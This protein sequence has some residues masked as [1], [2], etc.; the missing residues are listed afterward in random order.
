MQNSGFED[1]ELLSRSNGV[2]SLIPLH[3]CGNS[4]RNCFK[5][6]MFGKWIF[7]KAL[8]PVLESDSRYIEAFRKEQEIGLQL[9]HPN[10]PKYV[11]TPDLLPG[12]AFVA[13]EY[14]DGITLEKFLEANKNYFSLASH[15]EKFIRE[16]SSA[17]DYL[18]SHQILHLDLKPDNILI[19]RVGHN[20][21]II[22]FGFSKTDS[23]TGSE[24]FTSGFISPERVLSKDRTESADYYGLGKLLEYIR[25]HTPDYPVKKF[26]KLE[27]GLLASEPLRRIHTEREI[28]RML[29][30]KSRVPFLPFGI[31]L[32][33]V[34]GVAAAFIFMRQEKVPPV[35]EH[36]KTEAIREERFSIEDA[37]D[38]PAGAG[39]ATP[40]SVEQ[41]LTPLTRIPPAPE[42]TLNR[43]KPTKE[44]VEALQHAMDEAIRLHL[45]PISE[46]L[47]EALDNNDF[48]LST[49]ERLAREV[50]EMAPFIDAGPFLTQYPSFSEDAIYDM[51]VIRTAELEKTLWKKPWSEYM[52]K[53]IAYHDSVK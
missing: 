51:I 45:T 5:T 24:G 48:S 11:F 17:L 28:D 37:R 34:I 31:A 21:K 41:P 42:Q 38:E 40:F 14:I 43:E 26:K 6:R 44:S 47:R 1:N 52:K 27:S 29:P 50:T 53:F 15:V 9:D 32:I 35:E 25:L 30:G 7:I 36:N 20:V 3:S 16:T 18:H 2:I 33:A 8:N 4:F 12:R 39:A 46:D 10:L 19:T 22:D 23:H 13:M 49:R